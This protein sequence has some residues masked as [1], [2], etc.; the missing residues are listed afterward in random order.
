MN[1]KIYST[2]LKIQF[3]YDLSKES[4]WFINRNSFQKRFFLINKNMKTNVIKKSIIGN[5]DR[6]VP[7]LTIN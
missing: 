6:K 4:A 7:N 5:F 3:V 2:K 1:I